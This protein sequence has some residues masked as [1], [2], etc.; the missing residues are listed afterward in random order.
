MITAAL[1]LDKD[2]PAGSEGWVIRLPAM[3][4]PRPY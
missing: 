4:L 3:L 2:H 1:R